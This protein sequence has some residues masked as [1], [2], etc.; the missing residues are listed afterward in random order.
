MPKVK[1]SVLYAPHTPIIIKELDQE[2]PK[3]GEVRIKML[4]AGVCASDHH[5]IAGETSFEF[6]I[7]LG[8]EGSGI[9]DKV[10]PNVS[11]ISEGDKCCLLYT[12]PSPRD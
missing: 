7:V 5:V 11:S 9:V 12:S 8:H 1:A 3:S 2:E 6:P 4:N 10:G